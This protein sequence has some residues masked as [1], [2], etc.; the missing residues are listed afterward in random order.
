[1]T[2]PTYHYDVLIVGTGNAACCAAHSAVEKGA[3]IGMLEKASKLL[4]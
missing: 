2:D 4:A 3:K 1:M